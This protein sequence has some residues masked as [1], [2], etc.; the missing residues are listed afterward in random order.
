[1]LTTT[2]RSQSAAPT[3][4]RTIEVPLDY[5]KPNLG[6]AS[7]YFELGAPFDKSKPVGFIIADGQQFYVTRG[8]I[9]NWL[10]SIFGADFN[11]VGI[12]DRGFSETFTKAALDSFEQ[13]GFH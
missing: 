11:V 2:V 12:V 5:Q 13:G 10:K 8:S 4:G 9:A 6:K 1:M 3:L 7:L